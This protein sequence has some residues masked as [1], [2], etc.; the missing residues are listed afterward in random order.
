MSLRLQLILAQGSISTFSFFRCGAAK[1]WLGLCLFLR[2]A[3]IFCEVD[4]CV[5]SAGMFKDIICV[6]ARLS[7]RDRRAAHKHA[8]DLVAPRRIIRP[9]LAR[10]SRTDLKQTVIEKRRERAQARGRD[11]ERHFQVAHELRVR[12][13]ERARQALASARKE[14]DWVGRYGY[15][16]RATVK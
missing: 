11:S 16:R 7:A 13:R 1:T 6:H 14:R 8:L 15:L 10:A 12:S 5:H 3:R 2:P 4:P 9:R